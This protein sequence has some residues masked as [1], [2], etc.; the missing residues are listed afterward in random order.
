VPDRHIS[1]EVFSDDIP[2]MVAQA[3]V[4]TTW[5]KN[6]HVKLPVTTTRGE[7]LFEKK[8]QCIENCR[9]TGMKIVFVPTIVKGLNDNQLGDIVRIAI[10]NI[11]TVS[12]IS[13][14]PVAFTGRIA[15]K[16][17]EEKRFTL[18]DLAFAIS[19]QTGITDKYH[20][21]FPLSCV[22]PFSTL[23]AALENRGVP[24]ISCHPHCSL[25][26]YFFVDEKSKKAVPVTQFVDIPGMLQDMEQLSRKARGGILKYYHGSKAW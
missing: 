17:L 23:I 26:T 10:E 15:K 12:G 14:Q 4:I 8:M 24:T 9:K 7:P 16:E 18:P 21:W 5:G 11:D 22:T 6:V 13:F 19:D 1:F 3:R 2:E 20:D 25:G